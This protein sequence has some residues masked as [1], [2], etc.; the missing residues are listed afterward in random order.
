MIAFPSLIF[1]PTEKTI[2]ATDHQISRIGVEF[3][4]LFNAAIFI[5]QNGCKST[6]LE[7][8]RT[9]WAYFWGYNPLLKGRSIKI[10]LIFSDC[11]HISL[12]DLKEFIS[13]KLDQQW[14]PVFANP[15]NNKRLIQKITESKSHI[16]IVNLF[17]YDF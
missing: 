7:T 14:R 12:N 2:Q 13:E 6:V 15:V 9:G 8:K 3:A 4:S 17:L 10:A 16:E 5:D 1:I 11:E